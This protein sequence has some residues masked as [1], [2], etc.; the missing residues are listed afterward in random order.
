MSFLAAVWCVDDAM[1]PPEAPSKESQPDW[2]KVITFVVAMLVT[3]PPTKLTFINRALKL[4]KLELILYQSP[5]RIQFISQ[6]ARTTAK[7][8]AAGLITSMG[9]S[10]LRKLWGGL[11]GSEVLLKVWIGC[12]ISFKATLSSINLSIGSSMLKAMSK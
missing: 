8:P 3:K 10:E 12:D 5:F 11:P 6:A 1:D 2:K 4:P 7:D 9:G